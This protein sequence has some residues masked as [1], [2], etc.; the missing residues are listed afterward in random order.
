MIKNY[1]KLTY[2]EI[3]AY[4]LGAIYSKEKTIFRVFAPEK[5]VKLTLTTDYNLSLIHI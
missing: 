3:K 2:E 5:S 1:R 4:E